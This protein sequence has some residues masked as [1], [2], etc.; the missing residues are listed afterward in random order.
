L[1]HDDQANLVPKSKTYML[2]FFTAAWL[3]ALVPGV[4]YL[5]KY[6]NTAGKQGI[7]PAYLQNTSIPSGDPRLSTLVVALHPR[8]S[9][10]NATLAELEEASQTFKRP[11][12]AI[13]LIDEPDGST[14]QWQQVSSYREAQKALDA[15]VVLDPNGKLAASLG[16]FTSGEVLFYSP[17]DKAARR[18]LLFSGGVTGGR[19]MTGENGGIESLKTAFNDPER[20]PRAS[21]PVFGCGLLNAASVAIEGSKR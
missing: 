14:F 4:R 2:V 16:A 5:F 18:T 7:A 13:L 19:G 3:I 21:T 20:K 8:C 12:N 11:Y 15:T 17:E 9:C 10:S 1:S 6:E